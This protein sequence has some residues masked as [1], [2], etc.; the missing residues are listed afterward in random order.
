MSK[1]IP[2]GLHGN[3]WFDL[4]CPKINICYII[5]GR[6]FERLGQRSLTLNE[7]TIQS[8]MN[9]SVR[10]KMLITLMHISRH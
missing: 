9:L 1:V 7:C 5:S 10:K 4:Q 8:E 3:T 6:K 2:E